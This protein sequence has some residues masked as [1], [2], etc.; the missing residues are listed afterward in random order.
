MDF[1][2]AKISLQQKQQSFGALFDPTG[3]EQ[4]ERAVAA[5]GGIILR[6][7]DVVKFCC[8]LILCLPS[9]SYPFPEFSC[10]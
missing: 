10:V 7:K 9:G 3:K 8:R 5:L 6:E 2:F 1:N 4:G